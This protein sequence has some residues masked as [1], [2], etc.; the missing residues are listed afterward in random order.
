MNLIKYY[1][2][3]FIL[4]IFWTKKYRFTV[5]TIILMFISLLICYCVLEIINLL[6]NNKCCNI[7]N[8]VLYRCVYYNCIH[9]I[10]FILMERFTKKKNTIQSYILH[11]TVFHKEHILYM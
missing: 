10:R 6:I 11:A 8:I 7:H 3:I 2:C 1:H 5:K 4:N 9:K